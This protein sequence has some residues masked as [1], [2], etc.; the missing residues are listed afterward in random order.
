[1]TAVDTL[2]V[3]YHFTTHPQGFVCN[4][5]LRG[6]GGG[7]DY[8]LGIPIITPLSQ[9]WSESIKLPECSRVEPQLEPDTEMGIK[10]SMGWCC[11]FLGYHPKVT[12]R[13]FKGHCKFKLKKND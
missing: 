7:G 13:S 12:S 2:L 10:V 11:V 9:S 4:F 8:P 1:M 5:S 3:A 6:P